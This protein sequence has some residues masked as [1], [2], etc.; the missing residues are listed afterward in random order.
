M[1]IKT[2]V[3][4]AMMRGVDAGIDDVHYGNNVTMPAGKRLTLRVTLRGET[5]MFNVAG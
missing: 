5:A 1:G 4:V 2:H 3:P